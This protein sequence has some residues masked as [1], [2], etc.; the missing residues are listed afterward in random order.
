MKFLIYRGAEYTKKEVPNQKTKSRVQWY[1]IHV[2]D[3]N[4]N[5][6]NKKLGK[7]HDYDY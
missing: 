5:Y 2:Y 3:F 4:C 7:M 1:V 6:K